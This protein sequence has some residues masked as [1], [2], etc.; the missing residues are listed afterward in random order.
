MKI[1]LDGLDGRNFTL[2]LPRDAGGEHVVT[3]LD[4]RALRG[5]YAHD[6]TR[7]SLDPVEA[8]AITGEVAWVL[9]DGTL[10]LG[11]P[12]VLGPT[13]V[14]VDIRRDD[15]TPGVTGEARC[16]ALDAPVTRLHRA[17][18]ELYGALSFA[19]L[20]AR[21]DEA[22]GGW[23]VATDAL[24]AKGASLAQGGLQARLDRLTKH[25]R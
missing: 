18:L 24:G 14:D 2:R 23:V 11:G 10:H 9:A 4:T 25:P 20:S 5:L 8:D 22:A 13:R 19:A 6:A 15:A 3:L 17:G 7:F 16:A 21:H 12:A 1:T